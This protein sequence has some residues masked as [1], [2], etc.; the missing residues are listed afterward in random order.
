MSMLR[1]KW[2]TLVAV[3]LVGIISL[4]LMAGCAAP[5]RIAVVG[6][7]PQ[8][9]WVKTNVVSISHTS[10]I[11]KCDVFT[12]VE[13]GETNQIHL[14]NQPYKVVAHYDR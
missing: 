13:N 2:Q 11:P 14:Y 4:L 9:F 10:C 8:V 12:Y 1:T 5:T 6:G 7:W 3:V